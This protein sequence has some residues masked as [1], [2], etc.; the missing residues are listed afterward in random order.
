MDSAKNPSTYAQRLEKY[1]KRGFAV[2]LPGLRVLAHRI[3]DGTQRVLFCAPFLDAFFSCSKE[4]VDPMKMQRLVDIS[5]PVI[6]H[7]ILQAT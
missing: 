7:Y 6:V 5:A 1:A 3:G 2:G 4:V